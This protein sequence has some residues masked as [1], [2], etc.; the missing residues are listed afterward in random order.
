MQVIYIYYIYS[1]QSFIHFQVHSFPHYIVNAYSMPGAI[2]TF[3]VILTSL[4]V[5]EG[6]S[7]STHL[8]RPYGIGPGW[9][10]TLEALGC[11]SNSVWYIA[12][13]P[14]WDFLGGDLFPLPISLSPILR[15][16]LT[17]NREASLLQN[18][19][20]VSSRLISQYLITYVVV[21]YFLIVVRKFSP[22]QLFLSIWKKKVRSRAY[23]VP[24]SVLKFC[25]H[26]AIEALPQPLEM[27]KHPAHIF[28]MLNSKSET[29]S[30]FSEIL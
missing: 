19:S 2:G 26:L 20:F 5:P 9:K 24:G 12:H 7:V 11:S 8:H 17:C 16:C 15:G 21:W 27:D 18:E 1:L 14:F 6:T 22:C 3:S 23:L 30:I 28:Q 13:F 29:A 25:V 4:L 10:G